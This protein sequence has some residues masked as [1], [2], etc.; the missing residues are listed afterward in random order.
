MKKY[1]ILMKY[2]RHVFVLLGLFMVQ[3]SVHCQ[4]REL[5]PDKWLSV[6]DVKGP[7]KEV[8]EEEG[9]SR[10]HMTFNEEGL[11]TSY[12]WWTLE[13]TAKS[14]FHVHYEY[15][16]DT[17]LAT[18]VFLPSLD[19]NR[20]FFLNKRLLKGDYRGNGY[21]STSKVLYNKALSIDSI[22]TWGRERRIEIYNYEYAGYVIETR[23]NDVLSSVKGRW[24]LPKR[25]EVKTDSIFWPGSTL[26]QVSNDSLFHLPDGRVNREFHFW[27]NEKKGSFEK[28][29]RIF[30]YENDSLFIVST[31]EEDEKGVSQ[32]YER[33]TKEFDKYGNWLAYE[34][35]HGDDLYFDFPSAYSLKKRT[36]T[37]WDE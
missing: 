1:L 16:G 23:V 11:V 28:K 33:H 29:D 5:F 3:T 2:K 14:G 4:V 37:Y 30:K 17:L 7:V 18:K 21:F 25:I 31:T 10:S 32:Y 15:L 9:Y 22:V 12:L 35:V 19:T 8:L 27:E 34:E 26:M 24:S 36:I 6:F 13:D 20:E